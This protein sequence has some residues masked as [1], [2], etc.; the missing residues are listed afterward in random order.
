MKLFFFL[1]LFSFTTSLSAAEEVGE[2][3][4][5]NCKTYSPD[6]SNP[7]SPL[8]LAE[9]TAL[10]GYTYA[11]FTELTPAIYSGSLTTCL[12]LQIEL[13]D[14]ALLKLPNFSGIVFRG[15]ESKYLPSKVGEIFEWKAF[16]STSQRA[17][18]AKTFIRDAYLELSVLN[19]K[20]IK[21][22]SCAGNG[23]MTDEDEILIPRNSRFK[24]LSVVWT[25]MR[26][27]ASHDQES[28]WKLVKK[29]RAKQVP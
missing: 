27:P 13:L 18:I 7:E 6:R 20:N 21:L 17:D 3:Y 2:L 1:F 4:L 10:Y 14:R 28:S 29:I 19:G 8:S 25:L 22:Y 26:I 11:D 16:T 5:K 23:M 24:I 9:K 12:R 15:T